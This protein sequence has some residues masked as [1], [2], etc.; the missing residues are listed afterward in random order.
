MEKKGCSFCLHLATQTSIRNLVNTTRLFTLINRR[1]LTTQRRPLA[2][3]LPTRFT[4]PPL[5]SLSISRRTMSSITSIQLPS[6]PSLP[7]SNPEI[8]A[9]DLFKLACAQYISK[10][11]SIDLEKAY[12]G[13]ES[14][15]TGKNVLGDFVVAV[16][17]FRLKEKPQQVAEN[18]VNSVRTA[19]LY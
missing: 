14:G 17:R 11:L 19:Y 10:T 7:P 5:L 1:L 3:L 18:L 13:V 2:V 15:K 8:P 9:L 4:P 12:E 6:T 16:P